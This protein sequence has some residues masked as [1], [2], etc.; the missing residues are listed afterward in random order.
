ME[1]ECMEPQGME[2]QG[3][4]PQ[5]TE[6]QSMEPQS[7]E[8]AEEKVKGYWEKE[9]SSSKVTPSWKYLSLSVQSESMDILARSR[10]GEFMV[11]TF[12]E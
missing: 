1:P 8:H 5:G 2:P 10:S 4:E 9:L 11:R 6:P 7:M 3:M 12:F